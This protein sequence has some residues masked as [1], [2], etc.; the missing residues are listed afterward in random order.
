MRDPTNSTLQELLESSGGSLI[1][2]IVV[3]SDKLKI[4]TSFPLLYKALSE[5]MKASSSG[6][7]FE[8]G[9]KAILKISKFAYSIYIILY[10]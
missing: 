5:S 7:S 3:K 4:K 10:F 2:W 6:E 8:T 9:L 1:E